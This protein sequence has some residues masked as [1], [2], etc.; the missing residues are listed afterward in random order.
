M[1]K[2]QKR[3]YDRQRYLDKIK[4]QIF[5]DRR[6]RCCTILLKGKYGADNSIA[7]CGGCINNGSA[8]K[9]QNKRHY[10]KNRAKILKQVKEYTE[11]YKDYKKDYY[12]R[13]KQRN[14]TTAVKSTLELT[15]FA[16]TVR[17]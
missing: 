5:K 7:Y 11:Q 14:A 12:K 16:Q 2:E 6:C 8:K 13:W 4:P 1:T 9:D 15:S 3:E 10:K 17:M